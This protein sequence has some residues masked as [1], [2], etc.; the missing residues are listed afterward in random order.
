[1]QQTIGASGFFFYVWR[2]TWRL[3]ARLQGLK[4]TTDSAKGIRGSCSV[5]LRQSFQTRKTHETALHFCADRCGSGRTN[6][7][8]CGSG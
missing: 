6:G 3:S 4:R 5:V 2:E 8:L 7:R 1:L